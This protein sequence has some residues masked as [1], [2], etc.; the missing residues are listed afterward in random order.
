MTAFE[1]PVPIVSTGGLAA[2]LDEPALVLLKPDRRV[3]PRGCLLEPASLV[4][5]QGM[6]HDSVS[7]LDG[8]LPAWLAAGLSCAHAAEPPLARGDFVARPR[9]ELLCNIDHVSAA[10]GSQ[11]FTVLDARSEA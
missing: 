8:G 9:P 4:D 6:G 1:L 11:R 2:H 7:V 3:R 10:L 5:V